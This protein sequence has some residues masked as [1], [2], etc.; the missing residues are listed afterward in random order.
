[1]NI[2]LIVWDLDD[3]LWSGTLAENDDVQLF[4]ERAAYIRTLNGQ[5]IVSA[6]CSKNDTDVA[7]KKLI[8]FGLWDQFVFPKIS[9][10]PKAP[11][12]K[13]LIS[14]MQLRAENVLFIDDNIHNLQ[15]VKHLL[16]DISVVDANTD[17]CNLTL[18]D[19]LEQ[20]KGV[21]K[22]RIEEYRMLET[23]LRDSQTSNLPQEEFLR[24]CEICLTMVHR[25]DNL[26]FASRIEEL[27][28]RSNQLNFTKSRVA[29][30]SAPELIS[31][32][33]R[34]DCF[35][36]FVWDKY[37]YHGLVGF[38]A[39]E[40]ERSIVHFVF[41]CRIMHMG[42]ES[43]VLQELKRLFPDLDTSN[44][45][46]NPEK[47]DW[48]SGRAFHDSDVREKIY[49]GE[50]FNQQ[51][52][53]HL[54]IMANCQSG[55]IAHFSGLAGKATFDNAPQAFDPKTYIDRVFYLR[56]FLSEEYKLQHYPKL[57]VYGAFVDYANGY[58]PGIADEELEMN[59][60]P[61][62]VLQ[63]CNFIQQTDRKVLVII[64]LEEAPDHKIPSHFGV[65]RER[66]AYF[67]AIW[68]HVANDF[69]NLEVL[70]LNRIATAEEAIDVRH[71]S[72]PLLKKI[73]DQTRAWHDHMLAEDKAPAQE[74]A[75]A[76]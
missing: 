5:G 64:P 46:V 40:K 13:Q 47:A 48:I 32:I 43:W 71:Y 24:S 38:A 12:I 17:Q 62:C 26:D 75:A 61:H 56:F 4:S 25:M 66:L 44:I 57:L 37:G 19:L 65:T 23:R 31:D 49:R 41:S 29:A 53:R 67:N 70:D 42:I 6:I 55:A 39:L 21:R 8:E 35:S 11:V 7:K 10:S 59:A 20:T 52:P 18:I 54:R 69:S 73:A 14:E 74:L 16:P 2:K 58:W 30:G 27:I 1:M 22:S 50:F 28:N 34:Y 72:V 76:G 45:P 9:F 33:L 15:E 36:I 63:F 60:Y 3:T 51:E 68:R